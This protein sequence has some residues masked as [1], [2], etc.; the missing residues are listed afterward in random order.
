[1][2]IYIDSDSSGYICILKLPVWKMY[3]FCE[4]ILHHMWSRVS[5]I[6]DKLIK[7]LNRFVIATEGKTVPENFT[8]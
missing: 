7:S 1:L 8:L 3:S 6:T 2:L 4:E 5:R